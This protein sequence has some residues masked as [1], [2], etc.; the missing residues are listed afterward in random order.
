M[1]ME[2]GKIPMLYHLG[3]P[4]GFQPHLRRGRIWHLRAF[5]RRQVTI[6]RVEGIQVIYRNAHGRHQ[7]MAAGIFTHHYR[8]LAIPEFPPVK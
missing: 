1:S 4:P 8:P 7:Q 6:V 5:R 2:P 3:I